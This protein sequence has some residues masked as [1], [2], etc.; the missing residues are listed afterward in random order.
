MENIGTGWRDERE[1]FLG[2]QY[3]V[4]LSLVQLIKI[5][6]LDT[7]NVQTCIVLETV[8]KRN[9][10]KPT[11]NGFMS[12]AGTKAFLFIGILGTAVW[13]DQ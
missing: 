13:G 6:L 9:C 3:F 5:I 7:Y 1:L 2:P 11:L 10:G 8:Q 4:H 12:W